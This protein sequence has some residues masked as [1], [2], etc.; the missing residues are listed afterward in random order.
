MIL[1]CQLVCEIHRLTKL[2]FFIIQCSLQAV[3]FMVV[4]TRGAPSNRQWPKDV[5]A[6]F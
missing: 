4:L 3:A 6:H 1:A 5:F 2:A